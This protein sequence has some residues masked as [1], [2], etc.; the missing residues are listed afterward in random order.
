MPAEIAGLIV[1]TGILENPCPVKYYEHI[2]SY[3]II[4]R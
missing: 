1:A 3:H 4:S 2:V